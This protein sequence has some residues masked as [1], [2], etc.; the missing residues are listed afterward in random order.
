MKRLEE[1][2]EQIRDIRIQQYVVLVV[3]GLILG[4]ICLHG[5]GNTNASLLTDCRY[6]SG[7]KAGF[8]DGVRVRESV[9]P[10]PTP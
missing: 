2:E 3:L 7:Y 5:C 10:W 8:D 9:T 4:M 1:L 6:W